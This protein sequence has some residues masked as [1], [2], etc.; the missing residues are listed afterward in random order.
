MTVR[1]TIIFQSVKISAIESD[2]VKYPDL[3]KII[4]QIIWQG[5]VVSQ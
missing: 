4:L 2:P 3:G 1:K 5:E